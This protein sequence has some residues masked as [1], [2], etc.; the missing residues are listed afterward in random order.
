MQPITEMKKFITI[1]V[2]LT[3]VTIGLSMVLDNSMERIDLGDF[4]WIIP[5]FYFVL[6]IISYSIIYFGKSGR[7]ATFFARMAGGMMLRMFLCIIFITIYLYFSEVTNIPVVIYFM[8]L[9]FIYTTFEIYD[10]VY[11]LRTEKTTSKIAEK[12]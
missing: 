3:L 10:L 1:L 8:F 9:Y 2:G 4:T 11:K 7:Q 6:T 5:I 12:P